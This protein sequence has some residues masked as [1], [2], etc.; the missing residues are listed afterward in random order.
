MI[1]KAKL[2]VSSPP[3]STT[4]CVTSEKHLTSLS[5]TALARKK[6]IVLASIIMRKARDIAYKVLGRH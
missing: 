4:S 1:N 6:G 3:V 2:G 5:L